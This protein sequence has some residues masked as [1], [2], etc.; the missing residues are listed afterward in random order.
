[1][2]IKQSQCDSKAFYLYGG[3]TNQSTI[4][5]FT[6]F[7][8][9]LFGFLLRFYVLCVCCMNDLWLRM[10]FI[11][12]ILKTEDCERRDTDMNCIIIELHPSYKLIRDFLSIALAT[13]QFIFHSQENIQI[14]Q[15]YTFLWVW[16]ASL[17]LSRVNFSVRWELIKPKSEQPTYKSNYFVSLYFYSPS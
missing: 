15:N 8:C 14:T 3:L 17:S 5:L 1:M 6:D 12:N 9:L 10:G 7:C 4:L 2:Q 13:P 16:T 11:N